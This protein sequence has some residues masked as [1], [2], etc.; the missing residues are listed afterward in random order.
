MDGQLGS[1]P[2]VIIAFWTWA[3]HAVVM[4]AVSDDRER[5]HWF[6]VVGRL[7]P[8][9]G[10]RRCVSVCV[11]STIVIINLASPTPGASE[12]ASCTMCRRTRIDHVAKRQG[13]SSETTRRWASV[14]VSGHGWSAGFDSQRDL[15]FFHFAGCPPECATV[16]YPVYHAVRGGLWLAQR[17]HPRC[18][19]QR[20][21]EAVNVCGFW[22]LHAWLQPCHPK[23]YEKRPALFY[24]G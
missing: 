14:A 7:R 2:S 13:A 9:S 15:L 24:T 1:T 6:E 16:L 5:A 11:L 22:W 8:D 3:V 12:D 23:Q 18:S 20:R 21:V 4:G 10:D 19:S 17:L